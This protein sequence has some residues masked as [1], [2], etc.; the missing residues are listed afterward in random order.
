MQLM[1]GPACRWCLQ[2]L[3]K[4][5]KAWSTVEFLRG[6]F[7]AFSGAAQQHCNIPLWNECH[8]QRTDHTM[9]KVD[10]YNRYHPMDVHQCWSD[11]WWYMTRR[12]RRL[13]EFGPVSV[14]LEASPV[15]N[16]ASVRS[17]WIHCEV[18]QPH[19][20]QSVTLIHHVAT[21]MCLKLKNYVWKFTRPSSH[22]RVWYWDYYACSCISY[23]GICTTKLT[24]SWHKLAVI[25]CS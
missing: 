1:P 16:V 20:D 7:Y 12:D 17:S 23:I 21:W 2:D 9:E 8:R 5:S 25:P 6:Q 22:A 11:C 24:S 15:V 3:D 13:S 19:F 14:D 10:E 18:F 4:L